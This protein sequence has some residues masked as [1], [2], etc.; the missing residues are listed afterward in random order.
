MALDILFTETYQLGLLPGVPVAVESAP[1]QLGNISVNVFDQLGLD[2]NV[3]WTVRVSPSGSAYFSVQQSF[4]TDSETWYSLQ[5]NGAESVRYN[6]CY[7]SSFYSLYYGLGAYARRVWSTYSHHAGGTGHTRL[8]KVIS[9]LAV[10]MA[11]HLRYLVPTYEQDS[12]EARAKDEVVHFESVTLA[13]E[14][15]RLDRFCVAIQTLRGL[16]WSVCRTWLQ[17]LSLAFGTP[18]WRTSLSCFCSSCGIDFAVQV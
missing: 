12:L 5:A 17:R 14:H 10:S 15:E 2:D 3:S 13:E 1:L 7:E 9:S 8:H 16:G 4:A 11:G 18:Y 6:D